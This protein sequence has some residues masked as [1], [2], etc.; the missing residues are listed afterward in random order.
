MMNG[1]NI[2]A[3]NRNFVSHPGLQLFTM[4]RFTVFL[5]GNFPNPQNVALGSQQ[6]SA[7]ETEGSDRS[8]SSRFKKPGKING[9]FL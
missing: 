7:P 8:I 4:K 6:A 2:V 9:E 3:Q 5:P 1:N